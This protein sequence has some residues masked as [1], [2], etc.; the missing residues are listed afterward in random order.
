MHAVFVD[1][2]LAGFHLKD[3]E[4]GTPGYELKVHSS[5]SFG[6]RPRSDPAP[7]QRGTA[8]ARPVSPRIPAMD[9]KQREI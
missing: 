1:E 9:P 3:G 6:L 7:G 2:I 5:L 4:R 8:S